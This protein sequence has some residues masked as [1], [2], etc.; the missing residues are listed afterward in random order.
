MSTE[1]NKLYNRIIEELQAEIAYWRNRAEHS[2]AIADGMLT[3]EANYLAT[4]RHEQE[5]N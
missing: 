2:E 4:V 1:R 3:V 5:V